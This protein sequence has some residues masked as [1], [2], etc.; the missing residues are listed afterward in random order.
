M[1]C[2]QDLT[3]ES[4]G[5]TFSH[6]EFAPLQSS[7]WM[8]SSY[9]HLILTAQPSSASSKNTR[10][11]CPFAKV[12]LKWKIFLGL[13]LISPCFVTLYVLVPWVCVLRRQQECIVSSLSSSL[14]L[15]LLGEVGVC[16]I[17]VLWSAGTVCLLNGIN[18]PLQC[19][20]LKQ[21]TSMDSVHVVAPCSL[22]Q[23]VVLCRGTV[24]VVWVECLCVRG[25]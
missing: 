5:G 11:V 6:L 4:N 3:G 14:L 13:L 25:L 10:Y 7:M 18:L 20:F 22:W 12:C 23:L 21:E 2:M 1:S 17:L 15:Y 19:A 16:S 8:V 9:V 24:H